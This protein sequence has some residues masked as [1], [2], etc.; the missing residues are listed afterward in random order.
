M[1]CRVDL[2]PWAPYL[3]ENM[4][5]ERLVWIPSLHSYDVHPT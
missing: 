4:N 5:T 1:C 3:K 2:D